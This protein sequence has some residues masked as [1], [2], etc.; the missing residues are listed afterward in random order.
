LGL[1]EQVQAR[2][3]ELRELILKYDHH[4]Y[5]L[6][7]PLVSDGAYD[8]LMQELLALELQ[9]PHLVDESSPTRRV[10]GEANSKFPA[11]RH[12]Q[13]LLSLDNAFSYGDLRDFDIRVGKMLDVY[14]YVIELKI[15]GLSISLTYEKGFLIKAATRGD[16]NTGEDVTLNVR[17]IKSIPLKLL[18]PVERLE[19]RGE[20]F[21]PKAA[22]RR[23]NQERE[24][25]GKRVFANPRNAAAGSLRQLQPAV[26]AQRKLAAYFY[27]LLYVEGADIANQQEALSF[28]QKVGLPVI[29]D[30]K[31]VATI[32]EA[33]AYAGEFEKDRDNLS[34]EI[35]GAVIKLNS[36]PDRLLL[37]NTEKSPR[38][39]IAYKFAAEQIITK[40]LDVEINVGRTGI[41]APTALLEPVTLAGATVSRA[42]LHNFDFIREKGLRKGDMVLLHKAGDIIPEI[43]EPVLFERTG[44]EVEILPPAHCPACG[45]QAIRPAGE[46]AYR[47]DNMNCSA[48]LKE[49]IVFFASRT[50][51]DIEG[52][53]P[54]VVEQLTRTGLVIK[55]EDLYG[56]TRESIAALD[57]MGSKSADNLVFALERSKSQPLARL[58]T[59]LG[60]RHVGYRIA[61]VLADDLKD[62]NAFFHASEEELLA[63]PEIGP[64]IAESVVNF[65][66]EPRN[67][68]T[69]GSL[70]AAGLNYRQAAQDEP[71]RPLT[72]KCFVL[73]GTLQN[74]T[75]EEISKLIQ[76]RGGRVN[77]NV[78]AKTDYLVIGD[79][80]GKKYEQALKLKVAVLTEA[81]A[82]SLLSLRLIDM[83]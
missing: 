17:T 75:R 6:D 27:D 81:E 35:D 33:Y 71:D 82:E 34:Y 50:A 22:F 47:C 66:A 28:L 59:A 21:M 51:M 78:S 45:S 79:S 23:L 14:D 16:G 43:I 4:Y 39:A 72:G 20:I 57:R 10:G 69:V 3:R 49:S 5:V 48:R 74:Y 60:I 29:P 11:A 54:G 56:L 8:N 67:Q 83:V 2:I 37:G 73:S 1:N 55:V 41:I 44:N 68:E 52:L 70:M 9:N 40:L 25:Q 12:R 46:V 77:S 38:W 76:S 19:V 58:L 26:T 7:S 30:F 13:K 42:S 64:K 36:I 32:E 62:I 61:Q 31:A 80:P 63:I 65:F 15:D 53:G 18:S 24:E